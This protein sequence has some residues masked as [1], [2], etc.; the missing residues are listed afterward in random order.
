MLTNYLAANPP[1]PNPILH[2]SRTRSEVGEM[3]IWETESRQSIIRFKHPE[4][5]LSDCLG[6][7]P[8][9]PPS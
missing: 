4:V 9:D 3:I 7:P 1:P 5:C 2:N 8:C 6:C